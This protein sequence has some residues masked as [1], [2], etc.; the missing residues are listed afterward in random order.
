MV[1]HQYNLLSLKEL[2]I[3]MKNYFFIYLLFILT[4]FSF[5]ESEK[6]L[7]CKSPTAYAYHNGYCQGLKK[8]THEIIEVSREEAFNKYGKNKACGYCY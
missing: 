1:K 8:C 6:V 5:K 7:I 2:F 3:F 4:A